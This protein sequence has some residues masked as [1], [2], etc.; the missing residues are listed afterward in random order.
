M[1]DLDALLA[2]VE[3]EAE[4]LRAEPGWPTEAE[5]A[6]A[7]HLSATAPAGAVRPSLDRLVTAI[8]EA[9]FIRIDVPTASAR[10]PVKLAKVVLTRLL[11]FWFRFVVDQVTSLGVTTARTLRTVAGRLEE[12]ERRLDQIDAVPAAA[13]AARLPDATGGDH[14]FDAWRDDL[15]RLALAAGGRILYADEH[16][17]E[18]VA[19]LQVAGADAYGLSRDGERFDTTLELRHG[20]LLAH[21]GAVGADALGGV[22]LAGSP[23]RLD[24]PSFRALVAALAQAV[25]PGGTLAVAAEAP[26]SWRARVGSVEADLASGRPLSADTWL[27]AL[28]EAGFTATVA[29]TDDGRSYLVTARQGS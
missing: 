19:E 20:D 27:G 2:E 12:V 26:W 24:G 3:A 11:T 14:A 6:I 1:N 23:D 25:R 22:V 7:Q 18:L 5:E 13:G 21:L 15:V 17:A 8:E 9:S 4:R 28:H 10:P 29:H 16:T